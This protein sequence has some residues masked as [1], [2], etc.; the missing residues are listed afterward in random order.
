ME[1][2]SVGE[3][4]LIVLVGMFKLQIKD[5]LLEECHLGVIRF[6]KM[7]KHKKISILAKLTLITKLQLLKLLVV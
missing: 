7:L 6:P 1:E 5:K 4:I 3:P 2:Y